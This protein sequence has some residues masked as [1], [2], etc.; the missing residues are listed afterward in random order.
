MA[1]RGRSTYKPNHE[2]MGQFLLSPAVKRV[3]DAA[4]KDIANDAA[5]AERAR[6]KRSGRRSTGDLAASYVTGSVIAAGGE[7]G[8]GPR[9]AGTVGNTQPYAAA[10]ELGEG[11]F[12]GEHIL[13]R[14]ASA[15]H[16]PKAARDAK[17]AV[18]G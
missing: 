12:P 3:A 7:D 11:P 2:S 4:A 13:E 1:R 15:Y 6:P 9:H 8:Y 17:G 14:A 18:S 5:A 10:I 16:V